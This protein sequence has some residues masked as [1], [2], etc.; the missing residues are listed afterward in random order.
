MAA[1]SEKRRET[2]SLSINKNGKK[3]ECEKE[4]KL[5][6]ELESLFNRLLAKHESNCLFSLKAVTALIKQS[7][8]SMPVILKI[9]K[10][11]YEQL[12]QIYQK[13]GESN[14][15][16]LAA[17]ILSLIATVHSPREALKY[18]ILGTQSL[19]INFWGHDYVI[20]IM[21][22]LIATFREN[23][24]LNDNTSKVVKDVLKYLIIHNSISEAIDFAIEVKQVYL[25]EQF[26]ENEDTAIASCI[27]LKQSAIYAENNK[28]I[29]LINVAFK[30][31]KKF[32]HYIEALLLSL[33][34]KDTNTA[35]QLIN[36]VKDEVLRKQMIFVIA[37][38]QLPIDGVE[39]NEFQTLFSNHF[40][41]EVF[42]NA[43]KTFNVLKPK[44]PFEITE[45]MS[46]SSK[47]YE[48]LKK[49][50]K[51]D[52][53]EW[54]IINGFLNCG[55]G[56]DTLLTTEEEE[57]VL[58][59]INNRNDYITV[60]A[61]LGLIYRLH[62]EK[63]QEAIEKYIQSK[64]VKQRCGAILALC[65]MIKG[66]KY[67]KNVQ[68]MSKHLNAANEELK[69]A[70]IIGFG[71]SFAGQNR[72]EILDILQEILK[73]V[74]SNVNLFVYGTAALSCGLIALG[75]AN[76]ELSEVLLLTLLHLETTCL[77]FERNFNSWFLLLGIGF[78]FFG[79]HDKGDEIL[80]KL[81]LI[82]NAELREMAKILIT[83]C[84]YFASGDVLKV[85]Q[86]LK[87]CSKK[88]TEMDL[89]SNNSDLNP[90]ILNDKDN[91]NLGEF[92]D[93]LRSKSD[94]QLKDNQKT[95]NDESVRRRINSDR[96]QAH[97]VTSENS[98][99][100]HKQKESKYESKEEW[101]K[102][103]SQ[104]TRNINEFLKNAIK[105]MVTAPNQ[106]SASKHSTFDEFERRI[107]SVA[108]SLEK[109]VNRTQKANKNKNKN[110]NKPTGSDYELKIALSKEPKEKF[111]SEESDEY[112]KRR[113]LK[114]SSELPISNNKKPEQRDSSLSEILKNK[115][116]DPSVVDIPIKKREFQRSRKSSRYQLL[117]L[118]RKPSFAPKEKRNLEFF[119]ADPDKE[120][121]YEDSDASLE[122]NETH[123]VKS[124]KL[125]RFKI[126]SKPKKSKSSIKNF[127][128]KRKLNR[129]ND[130]T[131]IEKFFKTNKNYQQ[132]RNIANEEKISKVKSGP[133]QSI[134][135]DEFK[136][137]IKISQS[138]QS[139]KS[140]S[141][142]TRNSLNE[143]TSSSVK[144]KSESQKE[145]KSEDKSE[146]K[147][148]IKEQNISKA[149][150]SSS[151][152]KRM[153]QSHASTNGRRSP[154]RLNPF[155]KSLID[156]SRSSLLQAVAALGFGVITIGE[157]LGNQMAIR[158]CSHFFRLSDSQTKRT[159]PLI[160]AL[161]F[162]SNPQPTVVHILQKYS[163]DLN[164]DLAA[165]CIIALGLVGAGTNNS[166][167]ARHLRDLFRIYN[168]NSAM[169]LLI[170]IS[171]AL[172]FLG[173][174]LL[175]LSPYQFDKELIKDTS[176][177]SV[178]VVLLCCFDIRSTL[179]TRFKYL[180]YY[181]TPAIQS[182]VCTT[183]DE[184]LNPLQVN[185]RVGQRVD[186]TGKVGNLKTVTGFHTLSTPIT[187]EADERCEVASDEFLSFTPIIEDNVI[188]RRK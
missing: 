29:L 36:E 116:N 48:I 64:D 78:C 103:S 155:W 24:Q 188:L 1:K 72:S 127:S 67:N 123:R 89:R 159:A 14:E 83:A 44:N 7:T 79:R 65:I 154:N 183:F 9:M 187:I 145:E 133:K 73:N 39:D 57:K 102:E 144:S 114:I 117:N 169:K 180:I 128:K 119:G 11:Y 165:N 62:I 38:H 172:L 37:K 149:I 167:I 85:R 146:S 164:L 91:R 77:R 41:R 5:K 81:D 99:Q 4:L 86:F 42:I 88:S 118:R 18:R 106:R 69:M 55:F 110:G 153:T 84:I 13:L 136:D 121:D 143:I 16:R 151:R 98:N 176:V 47:W 113:S 74:Q 32:N 141:S 93:M 82:Q 35:K 181:L 100:S 20:H 186:I 92:K 131:E 58:T 173:K 63:G 171:H 25:L 175:S 19:D 129:M 68:L 182:K 22:D 174:G 132:S 184:N 33:K 166:R 2:S 52:L 158:I 71:I 107:K 137:S 60:I 95:R 43:A 108:K 49:S 178:L 66:M 139:A 150:A 168:R 27:Y 105:T 142:I 101:H 112:S 54:S 156:E 179:L 126:K 115:S 26:V 104:I 122:S 125:K 75:S 111:K 76:K 140:N 135:E 15:Q 157:T 61:S 8:L 109:K 163:S 51:L 10:P 124:R 23:P 53:V 134:F 130:K 17:D 185:V 6:H 148:A 12:K 96:S 59:L 45:S 90:T 30:L 138:L 177:A 97:S 56:S 50:R 161:L 87:I 3:V 152:A 94:S 162:L 46:E 28:K 80:I 147:K 34:V 160:L 70:T 170:C 120:S 21:N 31:Y 40:K